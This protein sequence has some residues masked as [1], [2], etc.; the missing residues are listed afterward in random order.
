MLSLSDLAAIGAILA[1]LGAFG[2]WCVNLIVG[3]LLS[4]R[5]EHVP[6][7]TEFMDLNSKVDRHYEESRKKFH[8]TNNLIQDG[9]LASSKHE[10]RIQNLEKKL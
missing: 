5:L 7:M 9:I 10:L 4:K 1:T 2:L 8:D 3:N 6:T